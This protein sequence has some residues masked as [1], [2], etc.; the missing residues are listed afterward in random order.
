MFEK[1]LEKISQSFSCA[2]ILGTSC[3]LAEFLGA[4]SNP[5]RRECGVEKSDGES[6]DGL[7]SNFDQF[8]FSHR[9]RLV[10]SRPLDR[11]FFLFF[12]LKSYTP[13]SLG[14]LSPLLHLILMI[15]P[16]IRIEVGRSRRSNLLWD[17]GGH[18]DTVSNAKNASYFPINRCKTHSTYLP[19]RFIANDG[20]LL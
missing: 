20:L 19:S 2:R 18:F 3:T 6:E 13:R 8:R 15:I 12:C 1:S 4:P 17:N 9:V 10:S 11:A 16:P 7:G 14:N 5:G